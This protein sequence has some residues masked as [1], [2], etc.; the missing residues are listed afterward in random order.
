MENKDKIIL[1]L[2]ADIG[3]DSIIYK[4][5][6]YDVR[7]I[8]SDIRVEN[9]HPPK[10]VYGIIANP[11]CT[12][13]SIA[14]SCAKLPRNMKQGMFLVK[15]C[16]RIIWEAQYYNISKHMPHKLNFW[17]IENPGTGYLKHY[18][19]KPAYTFQPYMYGE[20]YIK[21]TS[22]WGFFN[23]P[24]KTTPF[25]IAPKGRS[26]KDIITPMTHPNR[27]DR[28]HARSLC[29]INFAKAFYMVNR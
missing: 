29:P 13:F 28:M 3:S 1:H 16:L 20:N 24:A 5:Y 23:I 14:R 10:N 18:L 4:K 2:C 21:T 27:K 15:E 6:G 12:M 19:G 26:V 7:L 22:L 8:N 25:A 17:Y 9:Y 11:V